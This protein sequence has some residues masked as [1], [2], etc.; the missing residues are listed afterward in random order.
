MGHLLEKS[1][2]NHVH[3]I[4]F[5]MSPIVDSLCSIVYA[6]RGQA[7]TTDR[8]A[9]VDAVNGVG[10]LDAPVWMQEFVGRIASSEYTERLLK[11]P[12]GY[13]DGESGLMDTLLEID[14]TVLPLGIDDGGE[15]MVWH[16]PALDVLVYIGRETSGDFHNA[17]IRPRNEALNEWLSTQ[18]NLE[19]RQSDQPTPSTGTDN[20]M[21]SSGG[22]GVP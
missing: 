7:R 18:Y 12:P 5:T 14:E 3:E 22:P 15:S 11:I 13:P 20:P 10:I 9:I 6:I 17:A 1:I 2:S 8:Q 4:P 16:I 21:D 19:R